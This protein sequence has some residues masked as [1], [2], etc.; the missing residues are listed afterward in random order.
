MGEEAGEDD[1]KDENEEELVVSE[2]AGCAAMRAGAAFR[3]AAASAAA[4]AGRIGVISSS[5]G[6]GAGACMGLVPMQRAGGPTWL[7]AACG[8]GVGVRPPPAG[9]RWAWK[10]QFSER[11]HFIVHGGQLSLWASWVAEGMR[12]GSQGC[13]LWGCVVCSA[14]W[15]CR[16]ARGSLWQ[17]SVCFWVCRAAACVW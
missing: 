10:L 9:L 16:A 17:A 13:L 5:C 14:C 6:K 8:G 15:A 4:T 12:L 2:D 3:V 1:E 7:A 11:A